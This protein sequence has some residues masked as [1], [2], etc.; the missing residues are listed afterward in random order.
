MRF[1]DWSFAKEGETRTQTWFAIWPVKIGNE[2]RWL[3]RVTVEWKY[4]YVNAFLPPCMPYLKWQK[5]RFI[6]EQSI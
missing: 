4:I 3:E 2:I 6:D 5:M 1:T